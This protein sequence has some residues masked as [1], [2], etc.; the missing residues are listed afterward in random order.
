[1]TK[2][3]T[4]SLLIIL[5]LTS[6]LLSAA[7]FL[8]PH[9]VVRSPE[10]T[11]LSVIHMDS[12]NG[13]G[14]SYSWVPTT[15]EDQAIDPKNCGVS[16]LCP[17]TLYLPENPLRWVP[18][19]LGCDDPYA[20]HARRKYPRHRF[21]PSRIPVL[22]RQRCFRELF[23]SIFSPSLFPQCSDLYPNPPGRNSSL[24]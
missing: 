7:Y 19:R 22:P 24:C 6:L 8:T 12:P 23:L 1:M 9:A 15:E 11:Q 17:G 4:L 16:F 3:D 2:K 14:T 5:C 13:S 10:H 20:L 18:R 21:G